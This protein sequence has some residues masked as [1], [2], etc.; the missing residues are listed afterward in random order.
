MPHTNGRPT[1]RQIAAKVGVSVATVSRI[2]NP[3]EAH[4][5]RWASPLTVAAIQAA[6]AQ[7]GYRRNA[8]AV[9][10]RTSH[11]KTVGIMMPLVGDYVLST[12]Y[13]GIDQVARQHDMMTILTCA[14]DEPALRAE[15]TSTMLDHQVA[16]MIF[17]DA[18]LDDEFLDSIN[19]RGVPFTL[20]HRRHNNHVSV[21]ADDVTA[22]RLAAQHLI[23]LGRRRLAIISGERF[24][25]A[26]RDREQGFM[27]AVAEAGLPAPVLV[28]TGFD[29]AASRDAAL[30]MMERPP[31][32]DGVFAVHDS[33]ALGTI[34]V[35]RQYGLHVPDDVA[36]IGFY[37]TPMSMATDLTSID[38]DLMQMGRRSIQLLLD[39][40]GGKEITSE[41][42]PVSLAVRHSTDPSQP[43]GTNL[44]VT[45]LHKSHGPRCGPPYATVS[46]S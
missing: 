22:G 46:S 27:T 33:T 25:P 4:P 42:V 29:V 31:Y 2:L 7:L 24:V 39:R 1:Q 8:L 14:L 44:A 21:T 15:R 45:K 32:P 16:G 35:L 18:R 28:E 43:L 40:L 23:D 17:G 36:V 9:S 37:N 12:I 19:T 34:S 26:W 38:V 30:R 20:V 3:D 5:E 11:S 13:D 41:V 6:A 10:L